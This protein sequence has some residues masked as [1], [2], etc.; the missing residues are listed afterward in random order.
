MWQ[1]LAWNLSLYGILYRE[2]TTTGAGH[3]D[4]T[5]SSSI[6]IDKSSY[7]LWN[8][9]PMLY[10]ISMCQ[11]STWKL[12]AGK[13][14]MFC[15]FITSNMVPKPKQIVKYMLMKLIYWFI[16]LCIPHIHLEPWHISVTM[17]DSKYN[18]N[19]WQIFVPKTF[20]HF[21]GKRHINK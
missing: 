3:L 9:M 13:C 1:A 6:Y 10:I 21:C 8:I 11:L 2:V 7:M 15:F 14:F 18:K 5:F 20:L 19:I 4:K 17:T 16:Y 12:G